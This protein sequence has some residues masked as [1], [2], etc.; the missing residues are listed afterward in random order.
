LMVYTVTSTDENLEINVGRRLWGH[1]SAVSA[2][3]VTETGKAVSISANSEE[4]RYWELED[5]LSSSSQRKSSTAIQSLN[6]L[7]QAITSRGSGLGL[8][9]QDMK[10]KTQFV[11]RCVSFD[12]EQAI[13]V[14]ERDSRQIISCFDF[15]R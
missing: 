11:R 7:N 5:L 13:V 10:G 8:T 2:A 6:M 14:G 12:D 3:Q 1:T 9:V 15:G 4:M